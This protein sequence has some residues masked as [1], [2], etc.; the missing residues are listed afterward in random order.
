MGLV[1]LAL[2]IPAGGQADSTFHDLQEVTAIDVVVGLE[3]QGA[4]GFKA[5]GR[6]VKL[7]SG[8]RL[9]DFEVFVNGRKRTL[10]ALEEIRDDRPVTAE[11]WT[12]VIFIDQA[13]S[14]TRDLGMGLEAL[15]QRADD[16]TEIGPV[17]VLWRRVK[18]LQGT[19]QQITQLSGTQRQG[20]QLET[21][22]GP[23]GSEAA[24]AS[25]HV[26]ETV[27][28][29]TRDGGELRQTLAKIA[30]TVEG[31]DELTSVRYRLR[32]EL[33]DKPWT[34]RA[35]WRRIQEAQR[36]EEALAIDHQDTL[37][38]YLVDVGGSSGARRALYWVTSGFD[39]NPHQFYGLRRD[40]GLEGEGLQE[41]GP[42]EWGAKDENGV[43]SGHAAPKAQ[44]AEL[45]LSPLARETELFARTLSAYGWVVFPV[46]PPAPDPLRGKGSGKRLGKWR[47][48]GLMA[49]YEA[50]RLPDR[51]EAYL[52]LGDAHRSAG[53]WQEAADA[54][55]RAYFHF[56]GDPRTK[57][58]Q[59]VALV[60]LGEALEQLDQPTASRRA[61][62][63][64]VELDSEVA[65][66]AVRDRIQERAEAELWA[67][68][69]TDQAEGLLTIEDRMRF[70][71]GGLTNRFFPL[72]RIAQ[73]TSGRRLADHRQVFQAL[74][75]LRVRLRLTFQLEGASEGEL[76]PIVATWDQP[77][78]DDEPA[79]GPDAEKASL[80]YGRW[81]RSGVPARLTR[82]V[83]RRLLVEDAILPGAG[84][85]G[86]L[87]VEPLELVAGVLRVRLESIPGARPPNPLRIVVAA[88]GGGEPARVAELM[89]RPEDEAFSSVIEV[90]EPTLSVVWQDIEGGPWG[91]GRFPTG[92]E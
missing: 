56:W 84:L 6:G 33:L 60:G 80:R 90:H 35:A 70:L 30:L 19:Q 36:R 13:G 68:R 55:D 85:E 27:M 5:W 63:M 58:R 24:Q 1:G 57:S 11:P 61:L 12:Q 66:Q 77:S 28:A 4:K 49:T 50:E 15:S 26:L 8:V 69:D 88:G 78:P 89:W 38:T 76:K 59:A 40:G 42:Q 10:V 9:D 51:A 45:A 87:R 18:G 75:D 44:G 62:E 67:V 29:T 91:G 25:G 41:R 14:R 48:L 20:S 79:P 46:V 72:D 81:V 32:R 73:E 34:K 2:S 21:E 52:E 23:P 31:H 37:L 53:R 83:A 74:D 86:I 39:A 17:Q 65:E 7:P 64:A 3:L 22:P 54:Y 47:F 92:L 16:L 82:A 43:G 71:E